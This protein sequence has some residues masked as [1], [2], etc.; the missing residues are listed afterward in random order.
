MI[1][2]DG[3][4]LS[5]GCVHRRSSI[6]SAAFRSACLLL[7]ILSPIFVPKASSASFHLPVRNDSIHWQL[8]IQIEEVLVNFTET[9]RIITLTS[10]LR[11]KT[12]VFIYISHHE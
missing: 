9:N 10:V 4:L 7:T 2:D 12:R 5:S 1:L 8:H 6:I 3:W 11:R